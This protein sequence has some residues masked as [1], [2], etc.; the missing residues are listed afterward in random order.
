MGTRLLT[1]ACKSLPGHEGLLLCGA[2]WSHA[3]VFETQGGVHQQPRVYKVDSNHMH[4][5]CSSV[6]RHVDI[7][8]PQAALRWSQFLGDA[9]LVLFSPCSTGSA[10]HEPEDVYA[11]QRG[12]T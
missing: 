7:S 8:Q 1:T 5:Q 10:E 6:H 9:R 2:R 11:V 3:F 12:A 4:V